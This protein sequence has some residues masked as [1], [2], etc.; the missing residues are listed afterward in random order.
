MQRRLLLGLV[1]SVHL[2]NW[3]VFEFGLAIT[4]H[5]LVYLLVVRLSHILARLLL[6]WFRAG[7]RRNRL[8]RLIMSVLSF[9]L[10]LIN[11]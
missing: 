5:I 4:F 1:V 10:M 2:V 9:D 11:R 3:L 6:A 8:H 7:W